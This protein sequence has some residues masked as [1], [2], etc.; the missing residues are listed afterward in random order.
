MIARPQKHPLSGRLIVVGGQ[1]RKVGKTTLIEDVIKATPDL[2]W[3][4]V[5]ITPHAESHCPVNGSDCKC[6]PAEHTFS[7]YEELDRSG[8][9]GTS[10]YLLAGAQRSL[11]VQTKDNRVQDV[12]GPVAETLN[13]SQN[14]IVES[15]ALVRFWR[16][17]TFLMVLDS[18]M[19]DFKASARDV[20]PLADAFVFRS[21]SPELTD[22]SVLGEGRPRFLQPIGK[23]LPLELHAFLMHPF[24]LSAHP[25]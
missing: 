16:P 2:R 10:R 4:A 3:T 19:P 6:G 13:D 15:D 14:V 20:L 8:R 7:I 21:P 1:C 23:P 22:P 5:K 17:A 9:T 18:R 11:W 25:I 24:G 12:L